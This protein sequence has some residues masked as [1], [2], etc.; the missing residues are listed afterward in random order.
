MNHRTALLAL[1]ACAAPA[2]AQ[3]APAPTAAQAHAQ[4]TAA[5]EANA[6]LL[7]NPNALLVRFAPST[8]ATA[9]TS[10]L[11]VARASTLT[12]YSIVPGL[13]LVHTTLPPPQAAAILRASPGVLYA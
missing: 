3:L 10:I 1:A 13:Q 4:A 8:P 9:R 2:F 11:S 12:S 5:L 6:K 7:Y